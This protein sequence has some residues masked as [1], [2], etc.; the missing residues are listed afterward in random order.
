MKFDK[1]LLLALLLASQLLASPALA[2]QLL[3]GP[4]LQQVTTGSIIVKWRTDVMTDSI[5][6]YSQNASPLNQVAS[7]S[8]LHQDHEVR[9]TGL[10]AN[11]RYFYSVGDTTGTISSGTDHYFFTSPITGNSV[12]SRIWVLGD[13]GTADLSASS[14]RDAYQSFTGSRDTDLILM[15]GDNAY[16]DGLDIEYQDAVFE[17]Y[18]NLLRH[19]PVWSTLGN[20]EGHSA[21]S[22]SETGAYYDVFSLP[23]NAEAGG[24]ASGTEAYYSFD[25]GNV[26]FISLDSYE[27]DRSLGSP[28]MTWL[29]NDLAATSA[30]WIIAFW[31]HPP[32]TKGSHDSDLEA[33]LIDMRV[34]ALPILESYGVDLVLTGH[35]HSYERSYLI[36]GHYGSSGTF[37]E[38]MK[39]DGG[40][41]RESETGHYAKT[42]AGQ[43]NQG[44]VYVVSGSAGKTSSSGSMDHPAMLVNLV[45]LGSVVMD[46]NDNRL[47]VRFVNGT[48]SVADNFTILKGADV[49]PPAIVSASATNPNNLDV[50]FSEPINAVDASQNSNYS[51]S[52]GVSTSFGSLSPD[53]RTV[54]LVTT[55]L[56]EG[57]NYILSVT[58]LR[59]TADNAIVGVV[60]Q[61]FT[62]ENLYNRLYQDGVS[63]YG[64]TR[65]SYINSVLTGSNFGLLTTL[66]ADGNSSG[67]ETQTLIGWELSGLPANIT[68]KSASITLSV[69][70]PSVGSYYL[71]DANQGW[72]EG[73]V[74]WSNFDQMTAG[75][76]IHGQFNPSVNGLH[77]TNLNAAG[78]Q[79]LQS[80]IDGGLP[81]NGFVIANSLETDG[82]DFSSRESTIADRPRLQIVYSVGSS[83]PDTTPPSAPPGFAVTDLTDSQVSLEWGPAVDNVGVSFYRIYRRES[84]TPGLTLI[85]VV[86]GLVHVD[87]GLTE[88]TDF[89]YALAAVDAAGNESPLSLI[90]TT[91]LSMGAGSNGTTG[92]SSGGSVSNDSGNSGSL[93]PEILILNVL[94]GLAVWRRR[95]LQ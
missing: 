40:S 62:F 18:P 66:E 32:Y 75:N 10:A 13:S 82:F 63:S 93:G 56:A 55:V 2:A 65:D 9:I 69:K 92:G 50:T 35:S 46:F 76:T 80:W 33:N 71:F 3:R 90:N 60:A 72:Q 73:T 59:D 81:N 4:Y 41:G 20:H 47:D 26:H 87:T 25:Y 15:L 34:K 7:S 42:G 29:E 6:H 48:A 67:A 74:N 5:V 30:M 58:N 14:V 70:N 83:T 27:T 77:T 85:A 57:V 19:I 79:L 44:A 89:E 94:F 39:M 49:T 61:A 23:K 54:S 91:T 51:I 1:A 31:H 88:Q 11:T 68:V 86:N 78:I 45:S 8:G 12:S 52:Q 43:S 84:G 53:G 64:G 16:D 17:M 21:D 28:M 24:L 38:S 95:K 22:A 36:D 37:T